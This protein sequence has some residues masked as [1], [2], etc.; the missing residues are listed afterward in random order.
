[1]ERI[2]FAVVLLLTYLVASL[3]IKYDNKSIEAECTFKKGSNP[4]DKA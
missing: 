4:T 3:F 2:I 1:M